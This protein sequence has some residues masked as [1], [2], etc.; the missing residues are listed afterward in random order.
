MTPEQAAVCAVL[1]RHMS[2][3]L[4]RDKEAEI[5]AE[6]GAEVYA[7]ARK[8]IHEAI[9]TPV[10]WSKGDMNWALNAMGPPC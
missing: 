6:Y 1:D 3:S 2:S 4:L 9:N 5:V 10:D 8:I 7:Q